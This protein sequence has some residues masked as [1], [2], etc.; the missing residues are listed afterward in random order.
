MTDIYVVVNPTTFRFG[1]GSGATEVRYCP[2]SSM[3][4]PWRR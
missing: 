2:S 1:D 4:E 3:P